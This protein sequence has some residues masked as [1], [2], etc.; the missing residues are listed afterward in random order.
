MFYNFLIIFILVC[1][2]IKTLEGV[3]KDKQKF[4]KKVERRIPRSMSLK[5]MDKQI[6]DQKETEQ[7]R[8]RKLEKDNAELFRIIIKSN[9][10]INLEDFEKIFPGITKQ[11]H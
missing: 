11:L 8:V 3:M 4:D 9:M 1:I 6:F 10:D 5:Q 7:K 2:V